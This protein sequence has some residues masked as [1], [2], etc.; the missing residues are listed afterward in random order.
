M[1]AQRFICIASGTLMTTHAPVARGLAQH[2]TGW[3]EAMC[4]QHGTQVG[5]HRGVGSRCGLELASREPELDSKPESVD[6]LAILR[7]EKVGADNLVIRA[8]DENFGGGR[9]LAD[10]VIGVPAAC[11]GIAD[12]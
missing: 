7:P 9:I 11:V 2:V 4:L 8:V 10:T 12:L 1:E 5:S 6:E 3:A